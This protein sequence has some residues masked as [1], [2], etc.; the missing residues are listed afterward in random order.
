M[1]NTDVLS[2][3]R[4]SEKLFDSGA[5][6]FMHMLH[7]ET[8]FTFP[9]F[10]RI[11]QKRLGARTHVAK[12]QAFRISRPNKGMTDAFD[13]ILKALISGNA[14]LHELKL[15]LPRFAL[16]KLTGHTLDCD[17]SFVKLGK[18]RDL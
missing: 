9:A 2:H 11:S 18:N 4:A 15:F 14:S 17:A 1:L 10:N 5:V 7:P 12:S 8:W 13:K 6:F 16:L 3:L